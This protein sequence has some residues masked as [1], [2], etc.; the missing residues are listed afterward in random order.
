MGIPISFLWIGKKYSHALGNLWKL[1]SHI[2]ELCGNI[3]VF[4]IIFSCYEILHFPY[5]V[6]HLGL[7]ITSNLFKNPQPG[8]DMVFHRIFPFYGKSHIPNHWEL[9]GFSLNLNIRGSEEY[10]KSICF[11]ILF[12]YKVNSLFPY[13]GNFIGFCFTRNI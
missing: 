5:S 12:L 10:G 11:Q 4:P 8:N 2:W 1:V 3:S 6:D 9:H 7:V 13:F